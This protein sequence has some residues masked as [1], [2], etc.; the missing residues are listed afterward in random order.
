MG[1][2]E[3]FMSYVLDGVGAGTHFL[4]DTTAGSPLIGIVTGS[5]GIK[6]MLPESMERLRRTFSEG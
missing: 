4:T 6:D 3:R 5:S 1:I 2:Y